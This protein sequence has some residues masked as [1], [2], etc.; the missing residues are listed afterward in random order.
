MEDAQTFFSN[1]GNCQTPHVIVERTD[2]RYPLDL[3]MGTDSSA[4][5]FNQH[6]IFLY[7]VEIYKNELDRIIFSIKTYACSSVWKTIIFRFIISN[8]INCF[9][10][11]NKTPSLSRQ[12]LLLEFKKYYWPLQGNRLCR[13]SSDLHSILLLY[14]LLMKVFWPMIS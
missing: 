12:C 13:S 10:M 7:I 11:L 8:S 2:R 4:V 1:A 3:M 14:Y 6:L 9:L 5:Y